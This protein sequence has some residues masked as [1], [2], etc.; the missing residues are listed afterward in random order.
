MG[1][2]GEMKMLCPFCGEPYTE[3]MLKAYN[4][5]Y[6]CDTGCEYARIV[7]YCDSCKREVYVK[8]D[9]GEYEED[10]LKPEEWKKEIEKAL[11]PP[12]EEYED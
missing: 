1:G 5:S 10:D 3:Q 7:I 11:K 6:G 2:V 4:G 8:G 12:V 9:F